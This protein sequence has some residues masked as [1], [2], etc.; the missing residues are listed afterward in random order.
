MPLSSESLF[1][2]IKN[3][4]EATVLQGIAQG[5]VHKAS[6]GRTPL[7][8]AAECGSA[9]FG[10]MLLAAGACTDAKDNKGWTPLDCAIFNGHAEIAGILLEGGAER[11]W[12]LGLYETA[13]NGR[14]QMMT[15]LLAA[16]DDLGGKGGEHGETPLHIAA[17][18]GR[19]EIVT[20]LL[21][22][23]AD[24][25]LQTT[26]RETPL[27]LAAREGRTE[28]VTMLLAAGADPRVQNRRGLTARALCTYHDF[29]ETAALLEGAEEEW[30]RPF[31]LQVSANAKRTKLFFRTSSGAVAATLTWDA[32]RPVEELPNAVR[33]AIRSAGSD[34]PWRCDYT[35][36]L[37]SGKVLKTEPGTASLAEQLAL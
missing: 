7:H 25:L 24:P 36:E 8:Q 19:T 37:P 15:L 27:H 10:R 5:L 6:Y 13:K 9:T 23:G 30:S 2:A 1:D 29:P 16:G 31:L 32:E 4:D 12:T 20:M 33:T 3:G 35:F 17:S 28:I 14:V 26:L 18:E 22:A 21:A 11:C 34:A